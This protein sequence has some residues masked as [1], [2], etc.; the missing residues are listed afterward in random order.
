MSLDNIYVGLDM[1]TTKICV[2]VARKNEDDSI[3]ILG[4]GN[5]PSKGIRRGVVV[6]I[7]ATVDSIKKALVEAQ[8]MS[9]I[10]VKTVTAGLASGHIKSFNKRGTIAV[11]S[12]EVTKQD[13]DRVIESASAYNMQLGEEVLD[14]IPQQFILDGQTEIKDPVGMNGVRLEADVHIVTG[15]VSS[16]QNIIKCCEKAGI[17]VDDVILEQFASSQAV[18][19]EDEKEIGVCLIDG[20]GGTCDMAVYK[21]GAVFHTAVLQ[22]GGNHFTKDLSIGLSTPESEAEDLKKEHGCVWM[23]LVSDDEFV[24]VPTVGGRPPRRVGKPVFTQILQAR[25]EEVFHMFKGEL[26]KHKLLELMGAGVV[27]TGGFSNFEGIEELASE[28]FDLP[29]RVGRPINIG[30]LTDVVMD[31]RFSTGVGLAI[32][33]AKKGKGGQKISRGG[34]DKVF[35]NIFTRMKGWMS[36]FF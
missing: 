4:I 16:A 24:D 33:S 36:E 31:P 26:Q 12:S 25:A 15:A 13:V 29:V 21:Q 30:G 5:V 22:I 34:E 17:V 19:S 35:G 9:G 3:D 28:V 10:E 2:V 23:P 6:N 14:V 20:G 8:R 1:G 27:V 11:K 32:Y 7:E 18:L